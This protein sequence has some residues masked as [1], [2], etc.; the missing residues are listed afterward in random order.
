MWN[1]KENKV[2]LFYNIGEMTKNNEIN[3]EKML[4]AAKG[5]GLRG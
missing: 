2:T 4:A 3:A 1:A 5:F